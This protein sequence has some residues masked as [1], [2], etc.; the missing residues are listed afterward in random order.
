MKQLTKVFGYFG[1][2]SGNSLRHYRTWQ[3]FLLSAVSH[4][5]MSA[6]ATERLAP[7]K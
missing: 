6:A 3:N 4:F 7:K 2:D 5:C 1:I